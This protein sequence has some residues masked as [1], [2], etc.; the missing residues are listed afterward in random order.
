MGDGYSLIYLEN[1]FGEIKMEENQE[2]VLTRLPL[3]QDTDLL[4]E[5]CGDL[6]LQIPEDKA[7]NRK[8]L[9]RLISTYLLSEEVEN[10]EDQ[11]LAHFMRVKDKL[12][13]QAEGM[14][15]VAPVGGAPHIKVEHNPEDVAGTSNGK[16]TQ[17]GTVSITKFKDFKIH[18]M[19]GLPGQKDKLT[20]TSL[21]YQI[22]NAKSRGYPEKEISAAVIAA[23]APGSVLRNFLETSGDKPLQQ[24][25]STLKSYFKEGDATSVFNEMG[26]STQKDESE[27]EFCMRLIGLR[28]KVLILSNEQPEGSQYLKKNRY[29]TGFLIPYLVV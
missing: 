23:T 14:E 9:L 17:G 6:E 15:D 24:I 8:H 4:T 29:K 28:E 27:I 16:Q 11:G 3:V 2:T 26:N 1:L 13:I 5:I 10:T 22:Q 20:Y 19:I 21:S 7:G 18:G 25:M 12:V